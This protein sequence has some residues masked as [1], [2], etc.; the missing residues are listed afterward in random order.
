MEQQ[1]VIPSGMTADLQR[2]LL[3]DR[4]REQL[5]ILLCGTAHTKT[6]RRLL[7]RHLICVPSDGFARQSAGG[8]ELEGSFQRA[9]LR[10]AAAESLTQVD[11][12]THPGTGP[13]VSFSAI[14]DANERRLAAY[15]AERLPGTSY[16]SV[17][18]N[19]TATAARVWE[20]R[21][22]VPVAVDIAP[23]PLAGNAS[24]LQIAHCGTLG[25]V[26]GRFDRQV[27]AFG[28]ELQRRLAA[29]KV[30]VV[31]LGGV[32]SVLA[33]QLAHLGVARFVFVDHDVV[34]ETNLNRLV[35]ATPEDAAEERSKVEVAVRTV[36]RTNP[37]AQ[38]TALRCTVSTTR[39][40]RALRDCNLVIAATD[41][42][43]SRMVVNALS[44]QYLI[45]LVHVGVNLAP[46]GEGS[47]EDISGEVALP[48]QGRWCLVCAGLVSPHR[49]AQDLARPDERT[50]LEVRGYLPGTPA[51][52]VYHLNTVVAS[53]A[54]TEIHNLVW[55]FKPLHRYLIYRELPGE[56][57]PVDVQH[58]ERCLYCGADGLLGLGD[59]APLWRPQ[60]TY[61]ALPDALAEGDGVSADDILAEAE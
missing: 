35:G 59:L 25:A 13:A 28:P 29:L 49:A 22:G 4:S 30:G 8:L 23:P 47:F 20:V 34:E 61:G 2:H 17:V 31:G 6:V 11:I 3:T 19:G 54:A 58:S 46:D 56:L 43:A 44:C 12:H 57:L 14:D 15:L 36:R 51:P 18:T 27:R 60:R 40:Q 32:G 9:I 24:P 21:D 7:A 37:R 48:E 41:D 45:P 50:Q 55:P 39:A 5:A 33:D 52:A 26:T 53:L 1:I 16:A 10:R 38:V 42:D